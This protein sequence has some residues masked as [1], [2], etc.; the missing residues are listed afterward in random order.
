MFEKNDHMKL[1]D[2]FRSLFW[3]SNLMAN[4]GAE[5]RKKAVSNWSTEIVDRKY[6]ELY[7]NIRGLPVYQESQKVS[8][9]SNNLQPGK[10]IKIL[11]NI[12]N[13][14]TAGSRRS[15]LNL[16]VR[17]SKNSFEP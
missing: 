7:S 12:P 5:A 1:A 13:F 11:F 4:L 8:G 16:I 10:K 17:L 14:N 15:L 2:A 6:R 9:L 3:E